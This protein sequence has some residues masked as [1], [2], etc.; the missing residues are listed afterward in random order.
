[1]TQ[2]FYVVIP[3]RYHS[4][5]FPGKLLKDLGGKS[6]LER[7]YNQA[8]LAN[9][10]EVWIATDHEEVASHARHLGASVVMTKS[11]HQTGT[12]RIAEAVAQLGLPKNAVIVNVQGDEPFIAPEL[13]QQV[14][15]PEALVRSSIS[16]LCWPVSSM[17]EYRSPH[18]VKVVR[19]HLN[20]ALYFSRSP[21]PMFREGSVELSQVFR[22]IGLYAYRV[23]FLL[24][25]VDWPE[26]AIESFECLEQLRVLWRGHA[27][28]VEQ[29]CVPPTQ[30]INTP[31]DLDRARAWLST[32][33]R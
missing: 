11:E 31:E 13:I 19:N 21:I 28:Q 27:I 10:K 3:A 20:Q 9:P 2:S 26:C 29:A 22:H 17:E 30:D 6:V 1:M 14:A 25:Y 16:T 7:V 15:R 4:T 12:D 32:S 24:D 23:Q 33:T 8:C 18:V 5:R